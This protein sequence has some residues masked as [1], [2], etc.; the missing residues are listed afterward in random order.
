VGDVLGG[1]YKIERLIGKGAMGAV[2]AA[3]H[4]LLQKQVAIKVMTEEHSGTPQA[5]TR[6]FNE[7]RAAAGIEGEHVARVLDVGQLE[8]GAPFMVI[9]LLEGADL[10]RV[11]E[12]R[13]PLPAVEVVDWT[14]QALE[15]LAEAHSLGIVHRDL[16]PANLFLARRRDGTSI[17]KVLDFGISKQSAIHAGAAASPS[18]TA[19]SSLLGS[20]MYMAPEQ[21]RSAKSVDA[22]ADIWAMGVVVYELVTGR[23][24]FEAESIP[25][26]FVAVLE[27][28]PPPMATW[29]P[30]VPAGLEEV[31]LRCLSRDAGARFQDVAEL[32]TALEPFAGEGARPLVQRI[33]HLCKTA[34]EWTR[35][36]M[37]S[38]HLPQLRRPRVV[39]VAVAGVVA[40]MAVA[41]ALHFLAARQAA[42]GDTPASSSSAGPRPSAPGGVVRTR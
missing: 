13:G 19:T 4:E 32:A 26:L 20:P 3:R 8:G 10:A 24:P 28:T 9:E 21:L 30:D 5:V 23:L 6:F 41:G 42:G 12:Q 34:P 25:E 11:L 2:F 29:R 17:L 15:A 27:R 36:K 1:K 7:A 14:L 39:A 18:I 38:L 31:V 37:A 35:T 40:G 16:K 22:R 33:L